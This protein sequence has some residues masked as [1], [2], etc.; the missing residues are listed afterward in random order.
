MSAGLTILSHSLILKKIGL[1]RPY[2]FIRLCRRTRLR[3]ETPG[4]LGV[5]ARAL[6][7]GRNYQ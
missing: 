7:M 5:Q 2:S 6:P 3:R 4:N 1:L